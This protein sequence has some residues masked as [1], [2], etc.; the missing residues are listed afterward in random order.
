[1]GIIILTCQAFLLY[2]TGYSESSNDI[3]EEVKHRDSF[4]GFK[5]K[6]PQNH[7][8]D[9]QETN[10]KENEI[11]IEN[12]NE[13]NADQNVIQ[14]IIQG[15]VSLVQ[16]F[17]SYLDDESN[18]NEGNCDN[19][20]D[21]KAEEQISAQL[22]I[23]RIWQIAVPHTGTTTLENVLKSAVQQDIET[24]FKGNTDVC[25]SCS[26]TDFE[27][28]LSINSTAYSGGHADWTRA[29]QFQ[30]V[31]DVRAYFYLDLLIN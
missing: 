12:S 5:T 8:F 24:R 29:N 26:T 3:T 18:T 25:V 21:S 4:D 1:M 15:N 19:I 28:Y 23:R 16:E 14:N 9:N 30:D 22:P 11:N 6:A 10:Y 13:N 20:L 31:N 7:K 2:K 17:M 27:Y